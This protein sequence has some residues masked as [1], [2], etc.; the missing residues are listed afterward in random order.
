MSKI[1]LPEDY[2]WRDPPV[3]RIFQ[4]RA[5]R[6]TRLREHPQSAQQFAMLK[7]FYRTNIP[8]FLTDWGVTFDPRAPALGQSAIRPFIPFQRQ[9]DAI[10]FITERYRNQEDGNIKKTREVGMSWIAVAVGSALAILFEGIVVGYGSR[11]KELVDKKGNPDCLFWKARKFIE[12]LP[13][14]FRAGWNPNDS[15]E[16]RIPFPETGSYLLGEGGVEIGRGGRTSLTFID[17][18]AF[19]EQPRVV[20][21][22]LSFTTPCRIDFS[23]VNGP[24]TSFA[25]RCRNPE[26]PLFI[27]GWRDDPRKDQAWYDKVLAKKGPVVVAQEVDLDESAS[28]EGILIPQAWVQASIGLAEKLKLEPTGER[29][30]S[31]DLGDVGDDCAFAVKH[32]IELEHIEKWN[33]KDL[34]LWLSTERAF[35]ICD[36]H[37]L[38]SFLYDADGLGASVRGDANQINERR[39][40]KKE[41]VI[42]VDPFRGSASVIDPEKVVPGTDRKNKDFFANYKAQAYWGLRLRFQES[43]KAFNGQEYDPDVIISISPNC[44]EITAL[45]MELSQPT[46]QVNGSGKIVVNKKPDGARSPNLADSVMIVYAPRKLMKLYISDALLN[47]SERTV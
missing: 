2:D 37:N 17:E 40:S 24:A 14:E 32:G 11:K 16:C 39:A 34:N 13:E 26:I 30:G 36:Q 4:E 23:S 12:W 3:A 27:F 5:E 35:L 15:P 10:D 43:Y 6:L 20:D 19:L 9:V 45:L 42:D 47:R 7:E 31:F 1:I 33:G 46:Y 44:P 25:E 41:K 28:V 18:S 8:Q 21:A 38:D 22:A 29:L